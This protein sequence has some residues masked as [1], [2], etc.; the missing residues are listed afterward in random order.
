M[1]KKFNDLIYVLVLIFI[2]SSCSPEDANKPG[3]KVKPNGQLTDST[4]QMGRI[5]Y[6]NTPFIEWEMKLTGYKGNP[7][8]VLG[9]VVFYHLE[10][11]KTVTTHMFYDNNNTWKFR[12]TGTLE[13]QWSFT[14]FSKYDE[15]NG[16]KGNLFIQKHPE[17]IANGF[18]TSFGNKWGWQGTEKVFIPQYVMGKKISSYQG[19]MGDVK[20]DKIENDIQEFIIEHGFTGFHIPVEGDWIENG[21][22]VPEK[23]EVVEEIITK[24]YALGGASHIW[25]W[26]S[27]TKEPIPGGPLGDIDK[28]NLRYL[29]ARLGP[30]PGRSMGYGIDT[31]NGWILPEQPNEW[32]FYLEEKMGWDHLLGAKVGFDEKGFWAASPRPPRPPHD[33]AFR[34]P[35]A[36]KYISWLGGDYIGYTSYR[37]LFPRYKEVIQHHPDKPSLEEDRFRLRDSEN[38]RYKDYTPELTRRGLWHSAMA[39]GIGNIWGNLLPEADEGGSNP[40]P[41]K[42]Q[43]KTYSRFF[44]HRFLKNMEPEFKGPELQLSS[45]DSVHFIIYRE[46]TDFVRLQLESM[47]GSQPAVAVDTKKAYKEIKIGDILP[48]M[49]TWEAP[50]LSDWVIAVGDY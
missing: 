45:S 14:T 17:N 37:P 44:A 1:S 22:P 47:D 3:A 12:F 31:E 27:G 5:G 33:A 30:L 2:V 23:Y 7:F 34:S 49:F 48:G 40:Y 16:H 50:Y 8:D 46:D 38:W 21:K 18:I 11:G 6:L 41:I 9:R 15:L 32:K 29:A 42:N 13:G 19:I 24:V 10:S 43:I 20:K 28:Q 25:L 35:I 26:G 39:G 36:D 4:T